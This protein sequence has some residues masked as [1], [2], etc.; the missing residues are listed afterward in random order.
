M[1]VG[2]LCLMFLG[3]GMNNVPCIPLQAGQ[4]IKESRMLLQDAVGIC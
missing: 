2:T 4:L 3:S 1:L